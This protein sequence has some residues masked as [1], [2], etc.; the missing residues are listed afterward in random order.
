MQSGFSMR[1]DHG[2]CDLC[3]HDE[4]IRGQQLCPVCLEA[5]ARLAYAVGVHASP[6]PAG[7]GVENCPEEGREA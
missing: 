1:S 3:R 7:S 5:I 6:R 2:R 4:L